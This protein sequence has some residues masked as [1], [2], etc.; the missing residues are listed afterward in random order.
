MTFSEEFARLFVV[1]ESFVTLQS[2][3]NTFFI[4]DITNSLVKIKVGENQENKNLRMESI[5]TISKNFDRIAQIRKAHYNTANAIATILKENNL[6]GES[7]KT[8]Y[9]Q[10]LASK[11]LERAKLSSEFD[12]TNLYKNQLEAIHDLRDIKQLRILAN[13]FNAKPVHEVSLSTPVSIVQRNPYIVQLALVRA[14]GCCQ[15]VGC[16]AAPFFNMAEKPYLE[17]HHIIPL[18]NN[19]NDIETNVIALCPN[20]HREAHHGKRRKEMQQ[21]FLATITNSLPKA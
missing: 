15:C 8:S 12:L 17:V 20:H 7:G 19:G 10:T 9:L 4:R 21:Q 16:G 3:S 18:S 13:K 5:E 11:Y 6:L 2:A 1:N 14:N